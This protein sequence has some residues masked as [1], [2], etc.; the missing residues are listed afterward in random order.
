[1][2]AQVLRCRLAVMDMAERGDKA[3]KRVPDLTKVNVYGPHMTEWRYSS[4]KLRMRAG[5]VCVERKRFFSHEEGSAQW[6]R[7]GLACRGEK[8]WYVVCERHAGMG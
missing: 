1:M 2:R 8:R 3:C 4:A 7:G 5:N 6:M